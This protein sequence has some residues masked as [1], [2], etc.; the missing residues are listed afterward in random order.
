M[1]RSF[2]FTATLL[3][4]CFAY[5]SVTPGDDVDYHIYHGNKGYSYILPEESFYF[6]QKLKQN[7]EF[8]QGIYEQ[9]FSWKFHQRADLILLSSHS[10]VANGYATVVPNLKTVFFDGGAFL[11]DEFASRSWLNTLLS[12]E[13][14]HLYQLSA[15][16]GFSKSL[17]TF[18]GNQTV[19][20]FVFLVHP[21]L[22]LPTFILEGNATMN[23]N[24]W[25]EGG[26]LFSG[27][28]KALLMQM[29]RSGKITSSR[30]INDHIDFPFGYEKYI[31]GGFFQLYLAQRFGV[32]TTNDFFKKNAVHW[33]NPFLLDRTFLSTFQFG[34]E[35]LISDFIRYYQVEAIQFQESPFKGQTTSILRSPL[36]DD[37]KEVFFLTSPTGRENPQLQRIDRQ[38]QEWFSQ[39][40][41]L[42]LGKV[43]AWK[44][45]YYSRSFASVSPNLIKMGL[46]DY[47]RIGLEEFSGKV[48]YDIGPDNML[49]SLPEESFDEARLRT[50]D[51]VGS[52]IHSEPKFSENGDIYYFH[53][54]GDQRVL[55]KNETE[56][57]RFAGFDSKLI[58][59]T[60]DGEVFFI[61][62]SEFGSTI[63]SWKEGVFTRQSPYD[64]IVDARPLNSLW[65]FVELTAEGYKYYTD[66]LRPV[67]VSAP[68]FFPWPLKSYSLVNT[69]QERPSTQAPDDSISKNFQPYKGV[70]EL[71]FSSLLPWFG[72]STDYG[73]YG[74]A[75]ATFVDP[76]EH[77]FVQ[78]GAAKSA[79]GEYDGKFLY[80]S[81]RNQFKWYTGYLYN[82]IKS[83]SSSSNKTVGQE[84]EKSFFVG[85]EY[86]FYRKGYWTADWTTDLSY[87]FDS[88]HAEPEYYDLKTWLSARYLIQPPIAYKATSYWFLNLGYRGRANAPKW[89][90]NDDSFVGAIGGLMDLGHE[91]LVSAQVK[92]S[93]ATSNIIT[94]SNTGSSIHSTPFDFKTLR[95]T[96]ETRL[97]EI[98]K[99]DISIQKV[100]PLSYYFSVFPISLR[101]VAPFVQ[102]NYFH[103]YESKTLDN[104]FNELMYGAE[105]E[106]LLLHK[107]PIRT[108][109]SKVESTETSS[110]EW[111]FH[112]GF[113]GAF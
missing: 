89:S 78:F 19:F 10:Q 27:A 3:I 95:L 90:Q 38:T 34:Y 58:W 99:A 9:E 62:P 15:K 67:T 35:E 36:N 47:R 105:L 74:Q 31:I 49:F 52:F 21:N 60:R 42:P 84:V 46:Y 40:V 22:F 77:H 54:K 73:L 109:F 57:M 81:S 13:S 86:R 94:L 20:P 61:A 50:K 51:G 63:Y 96:D 30:L 2:L 7:N 100:L 17:H 82:E 55:I 64:S 87:V 97:R 39:E 5:G 101:Q 48:V 93:I 98:Q 110:S 12:H 113:Q 91:W 83:I 43:F 68:Y 23:E 14:A 88:V 1:F 28:N 41:T 11:L 25:S 56:V 8:I 33:I 32:D 76:L 108:S 92:Q 65:I 72:Q 107:M 111:Q 53:Q 75:F 70:N 104:Q 16:D 106:L 102:Y 80:Q 24:R 29:V 103:K 45:S 85:S 44:D 69:E 112:I 37:S 79:F 26:R 4:S 66:S 6:F 18:M 71:R 59:I